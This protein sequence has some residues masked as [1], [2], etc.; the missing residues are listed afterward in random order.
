MDTLD[1]LARATCGFGAGATDGFGPGATSGFGAGGP[2]DWA[3][4][5]AANEAAVIPL[6]EPG[7]GSLPPL[8]G[9]GGTTSR[10][11]PGSPARGRPMRSVKTSSTIC[12]VER[13]SLAG[14]AC[15]A[16]YFWRICSS[17]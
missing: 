12:R 4:A 15:L 13:L 5:S 17:L 7:A 6:D 16:E 9:I 10:P 14:S 11:A 1:E 2:S 8:L 3:S